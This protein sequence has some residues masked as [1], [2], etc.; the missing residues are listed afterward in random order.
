MR[1]TAVSA[2]D[3]DA[4]LADLRRRWGE[5]YRITWDSGQFRA[6]HIVSGRALDADSAADLHTVIRHHY[7]SH[8]A[9]GGSHASACRATNARRPTA[10]HKTGQ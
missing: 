10:L 7:A 3:V 6:T 1:A 4:D 5:A 9:G 2:P 8:A